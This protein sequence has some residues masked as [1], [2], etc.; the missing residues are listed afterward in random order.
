MAITSAERLGKAIAARLDEL[1]LTLSEWARQSG[2]SAVTL[3]R[4]RDATAERVSASKERPAERALG[5]MPGSMQAI[6]SGGKPSLAVP[7]RSVPD[8]L[9]DEEW[10]AI[11]HLVAVLRRGRA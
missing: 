5:W 4:L 8:D 3:R 2:V 7:G 10:A 1:G 9:T 11:Q 6:R